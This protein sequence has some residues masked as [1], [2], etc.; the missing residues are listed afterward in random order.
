M[1]ER[2]KRDPN[3]V[4]KWYCAKCAQ[5]MNHVSKLNTRIMPLSEVLLLPEHPKCEGYIRSHECKNPHC[6]NEIDIV[7][8]RS[9]DFWNLVH[10][11][12]GDFTLRQEFK[13]LRDANN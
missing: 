8:L 5:P 12:K 3:L 1:T 6:K 10:S 4:Q 7:L 13:P 2:L 11:Q 9:E